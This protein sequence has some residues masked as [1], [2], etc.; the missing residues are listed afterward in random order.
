MWLTY[1]YE[2]EIIK[3]LKM[4]F[5][6]TSVPHLVVLKRTGNDINDIDAVKD[7][8]SGWKVYKKWIESEVYF[9]SP[10]KSPM[11]SPKKELK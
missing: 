5:S 10:K 9:G 4:R 3:N 6:V 11:K 1:E 2:A 8:M 7:V